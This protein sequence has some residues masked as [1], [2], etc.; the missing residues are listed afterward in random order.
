MK[1]ENTR[2]KNA[3]IWYFQNKNG[4]IKSKSIRRG[5]QMMRSAI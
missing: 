3:H 4:E 5:I 1:H 2:Q